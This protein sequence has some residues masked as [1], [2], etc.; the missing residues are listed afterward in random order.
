VN[1]KALITIKTSKDGKYCSNSCPGM[2][3]CGE[4]CNTF[5]GELGSV[6]VGN[7]CDRFKAIRCRACV[8]STNE[9]D[10]LVESNL[11]KL[12]D[13]DPRTRDWNS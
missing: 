8:R 6:A 9:Y 5:K 10:K 13:S 7:T 2:N 4:V 1:R 11:K 12:A 3:V